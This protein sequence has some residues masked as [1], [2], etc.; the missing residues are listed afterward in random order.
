MT[1]PSVVFRTNPLTVADYDEAIQNL[2]DARNQI[3]ADELWRGCGYCHS[4]EHH[5]DACHHNPL[6]LARELVQKRESEYWRCFHCGVVFALAE[7]AQALQHFGLR[8]VGRMPRCLTKFLAAA[9]LEYEQTT[10]DDGAPAFVLRRSAARDAEIMLLRE[11]SAAMAEELVANA[12]KGSFSGWQPDA[13]ALLS[14]TAHHMAKLRAALA[15]H[16]VV[17]TR[18]HAADVANYAMKAWQL[19]G[20]L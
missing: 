12:G 6:V 7:E 10:D 8:E 13:D 18:E 2:T 19:A 3:A 1:Q 9:G 14:E 11:F 17:A 15:S 4:K 16:D 5:P 20:V